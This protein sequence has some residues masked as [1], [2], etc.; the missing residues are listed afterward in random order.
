M[1]LDSHAA[2]LL[3]K[4]N[5]THKDVAVYRHTVITY[6]RITAVLL[7]DA[8]SVSSCVYRSLSSCG[9]TFCFRTGRRP[10]RR[11]LLLKETLFMSRVCP[12]GPRPTSGPTVKPCRYSERSF[13]CSVGGNALQIYSIN[14]YIYIYIYIY[15]FVYL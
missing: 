12:T 7:C 14:I 3:Y 5:I 8:G 11:M 1:Y 6:G 15:I 10:A 2:E 9:W 13:I 4:R